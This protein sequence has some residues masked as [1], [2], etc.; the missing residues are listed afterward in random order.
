MKKVNST[1]ADTNEPVQLADGIWWVGHALPDD[2][3][4]CNVYLIE[5]R[6]DSVLIPLCQHRCRLT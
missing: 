3:F 1:K 6:R 4:Q 5:N 2:K